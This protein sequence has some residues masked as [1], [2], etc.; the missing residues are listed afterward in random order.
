MPPPGGGNIARL[1][2]RPAAGGFRR[3]PISNPSYRKE[4]Q[5]RLCGPW[6]PD[7]NHGK[8]PDSGSNPDGLLRCAAD[9]FASACAPIGTAY[10][11]CASDVDRL[12]LS[13]RLFVAVSLCDR[14]RALA[15]RIVTVITSGRRNVA[16]VRGGSTRPIFLRVTC[17]DKKKLRDGRKNDGKFRQTHS[18]FLTS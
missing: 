9:P 15:V 3:R 16:S 4:A 11:T 5:E 6:W 2:M 17:A 18:N 13:A 12:L 10:G 7:R 8:Q 14:S 1:R